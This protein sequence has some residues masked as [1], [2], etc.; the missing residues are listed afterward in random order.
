MATIQRMLEGLAIR[1]S[2]PFPAYAEARSGCRGSGDRLP[3]VFPGTAPHPA[4]S[5]ASRRTSVGPKPAT[6]SSA[7]SPRVRS[8]R[9]A[10]AHSVNIPGWGAARTVRRATRPGRRHPG[11]SRK[12]GPTKHA[13]CRQTTWPDR[14]GAAGAGCVYGSMRW[15]LRFQWEASNPR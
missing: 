10:P 6:A 5:D 13:A 12:A 7:C 11:P 14:D 1:P 8:N 2:R 9:I 15:P 3:A 4:E